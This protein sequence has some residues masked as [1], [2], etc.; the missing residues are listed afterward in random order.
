MSLGTFE[1]R[2]E[3]R[4]KYYSPIEFSLKSEPDRTIRGIGTNVSKSGLGIFSYA[5]LYEGQEIIV[6]G[7]LPNTRVEYAVR[8]SSEL[9]E[10]FFRAGL[11]ATG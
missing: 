7:G 3:P 2:S 5:P 4:E 9:M 6:K 10:N 1:R 11:R 8:W